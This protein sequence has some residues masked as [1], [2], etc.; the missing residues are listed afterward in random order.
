MQKRI[1]LALTLSMLVIIPIAA[2]HADELIQA[3]VRPTGALRLIGDDF[4]RQ[5][6]RQHEMLVD[7][8]AAN[9]VAEQVADLEGRIEAVEEQTAD[10][11]GR[12]TTLEGQVTALED[13]QLRCGLVSI[14][15][16]GFFG[17]GNIV[18]VAVSCPAERLVTGGGC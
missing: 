13:R 17:N 4:R 18:E 11:G 5:S 14:N 6:C 2:T 12:T 8:P 16:S 10:L 7:W 15:Q 1:G 9:G 3:C